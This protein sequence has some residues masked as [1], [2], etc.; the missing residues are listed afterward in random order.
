MAVV[1]ART[2]QMDLGEMI[3]GSRTAPTVAGGNRATPPSRETGRALLAW[4]FNLRSPALEPVG[5]A[6]SSSHEPFR[7]AR[8]QVRAH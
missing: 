4:D 6:V 2:L 5:R 7:Y 8:T 3:L 1:I